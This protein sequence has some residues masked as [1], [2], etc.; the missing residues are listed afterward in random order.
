M[1]YDEYN[2]AKRCLKTIEEL[3]DPKN[4]RL[5]SKDLYHRIEK[6]IK[7]CEN[8]MTAFG[9]SKSF[10]DF[11]REKKGEKRRFPLEEQESISEDGD[12]LGF[13][14]KRIYKQSVSMTTTT[15]DSFGLRH[16]DTYYASK[17]EE[18]EMFLPFEE[19]SQGLQTSVEV[20]EMDKF[21]RKGSPNDSLRGTPSI[22]TTDE[23]LF[24]FV[25]C[26]FLL[27]FCTLPLSFSQAI[28]S[29]RSNEAYME[30][31]KEIE[32]LKEL[33]RLVNKINID[34]LNQQLSLDNHLFGQRKEAEVRI[35]A[36]SYSL[37]PIISSFMAASGGDITQ[38]KRVLFR[39]GIRRTREGLEDPKN[40]DLVA[41][42]MDWQRFHLLTNK[43]AN[44]KGPIKEREM[45]NMLP[46]AKMKSVPANKRRDDRTTW[47]ALSLPSLD[48]SFE[49]Q[50]GE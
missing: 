24:F 25:L 7:D 14:S 33:N 6:P 35:D 50:K 23:V 31:F 21:E 27:L 3:E 13:A 40:Q 49:T 19:D 44:Q 48:I 41:D 22:I 9:L 5:I 11:G 38:Y 4:S 10:G 45:G 2:H 47:T 46:K 37:V 15:L 1:P 36:M 20:I 26:P 28:G 39:A 30:M 12:N 42:V 16:K 32:E 8:S 29:K 17:E 43:G 34:V 18:E